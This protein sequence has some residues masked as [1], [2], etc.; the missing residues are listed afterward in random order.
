[1]LFPQKRES[2]QGTFTMNERPFRGN[3]VLASIV[4]VALFPQGK[5]ILRGIAA[6]ID[7]I[8]LQ[9]FSAVQFL[10]TTNKRQRCA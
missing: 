10:P 8:P 9:L 3:D 4:I 6:S 1:M 5:Y 7:G 2:I